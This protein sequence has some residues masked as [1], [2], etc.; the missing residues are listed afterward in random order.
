MFDSLFAEP[1]PALIEQ[2]AMARRYANK[3]GH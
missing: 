3:H 2:R 1:T